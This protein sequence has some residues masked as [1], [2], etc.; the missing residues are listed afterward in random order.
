MPEQ[1]SPRK[2]PDYPLTKDYFGLT[3]PLDI[4]GF[5]EIGV[6]KWLEEKERLDIAA[7]LTIADFMHAILHVLPEPLASYY[8]SREESDGDEP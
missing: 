5:T 2:L 8:T 3:K 6:G 1:S 4:A 7:M